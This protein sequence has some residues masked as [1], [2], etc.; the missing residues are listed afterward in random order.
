MGRQQSQ[1]MPDHG[2]RNVSS[3]MVQTPSV[4]PSKQAAT[5][6]TALVVMWKQ[7]PAPHHG[8]P[9]ESL[10][11]NGEVAEPVDARPQ[12]PECE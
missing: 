12:D 4:Q 7:P 2:I 6:R 11:D 8:T 9:E 3:T 1:W 5:I 10:D